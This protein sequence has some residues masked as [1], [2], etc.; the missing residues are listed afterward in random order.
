MLFSLLAPIG[1]ALVVAFSA[2]T[3]YHVLNEIAL[4]LDPDHSVELPPGHLIGQIGLVLFG[5]GISAST[6]AR[7]PRSTLVRGF[8]VGGAIA[9][10]ISVLAI[11]FGTWELHGAFQHLAS[12]PGVDYASFV[13]R[14][15]TAASPLFV[16]WVCVFLG[17]T[18]VFSTDRLPVSAPSQ[19]RPRGA[20]LIAFGGAFVSSLCFLLAAIWSVSALRFLEQTLST[21]RVQPT[22]IATGVTAMIAASY[23]TVVGIAGC[24][25]ATLLM[26]IGTE[27]SASD[28]SKKQDFH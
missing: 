11:G 14:V 7:R 21:P 8:L 9:F 10:G 5:L 17:G 26:A 1:A 2:L 16:G 22:Q 4:T 15:S 20:R 23:W 24:T 13:Q 25:C 6:L 3:P 12:E 28:S 19:N 27:R 18:L